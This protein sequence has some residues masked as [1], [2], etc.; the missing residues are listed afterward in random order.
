MTK[1]IIF[2]NRDE[3]G[4]LHCDA[5]GHDMP[6]PVAF[7]SDLIGTP[8]PKCG[9]D[10]LTRKDYDHALLTFSAFDWLNKWF[11]WLGAE[12]P[13]PGMKTSKIKIHDGEID[14]RLKL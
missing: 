3:A 6:G 12:Q 8:C 5:C 10:M 13:K 4:Q 14:L 2:F 9:A 11:G 7:T 1:K